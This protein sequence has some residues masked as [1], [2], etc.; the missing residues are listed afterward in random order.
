MFRRYVLRKADKAMQA[1]LIED[2]FG[3]AILSD[4]EEALLRGLHVLDASVQAHVFQYV[5]I[6]AAAAARVHAGEG[7]PSPSAAAPRPRRAAT[8][9]KSRARKP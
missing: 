7:S 3:R 9:A 1:Q 5:A 2:L 6:L 4:D 8:R